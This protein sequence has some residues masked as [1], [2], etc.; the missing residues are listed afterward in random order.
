MNGN[1]WMSELFFV[2]SCLTLKCVQFFLFQ[3][4]LYERR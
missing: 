1:E 3:N 2:N 4:K